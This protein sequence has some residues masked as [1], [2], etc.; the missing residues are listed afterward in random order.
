MN[1]K[2]DYFETKMV[3]ILLIFQLHMRFEASM[4]IFFKYLKSYKK[5][6]TKVNQLK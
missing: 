5:K 2:K 6:L 4:K 1:T 3:F